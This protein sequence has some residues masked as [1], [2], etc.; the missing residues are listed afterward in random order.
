MKNDIFIKRLIVFENYDVVANIVSLYENYDVVA[1]I[2]S[3]YGQ[4][5]HLFV[6]LIIY[7]P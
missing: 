4:C 2:V 6:G 3:L 1:N 5:V 7:A